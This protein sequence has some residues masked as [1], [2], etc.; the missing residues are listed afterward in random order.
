[1][2]RKI[3]L[4]Y[5]YALSNSKDIDKTINNLD[6]GKLT[7]IAVAF[8]E[9]RQSNDLWLPCIAE[10]ISATV[11][12]LKSKIKSQN[13]DTKIILSVGGAFADGFCQASRTAENRRAFVEE[14]IKIVERLQLDGV[15]MDWEF[16]GSAALGIESCKNCKKD[17]ILLLTEIKKQ[18]KDRLL[19]VAVGSNRYIGIDVKALAEI[20]DYVFVMTYDLGVT[21]SDFYLTKLFVTM[22]RLFG[23]SNSKLCVGVPFYGKN[24]KHL[25]E[26]NP[27]CYLRN[28]K[29]ISRINQSYAEIDNK[30]WCFDTPDDV[31]K[32]GLWANKHNLGG[33][34][35]W[36][37]SSDFNNQLLTAMHDSINGKTDNK[38]R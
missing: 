18:L 11:H 35:C 28:G 25:D 22:W 16:P 15:D 5:L 30:K 36:E 3:C 20:V 37:L 31:R 29:I 2:K 9:I 14:L 19:T 38:L 7:H 23:I 6:F 8:A 1:M 32:K 12:K 4:G 27:F 33:I 26:T 13:A 24:I 10:N 17:Y 21:H 34:F